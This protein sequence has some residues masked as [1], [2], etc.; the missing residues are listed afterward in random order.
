MITDLFFKGGYAGLQCKPVG[1][2]IPNKIH[3]NLKKM[4]I[5]RIIL[6]LIL[7][8]GLSGLQK[9]TAQTATLGDVIAN[10]GDNI[11]VPI[12]FN[13]M[14][15]LGS[16]TLFILFDENVLTFNG[17][18]NVVPE[19]AGTFYNYIPN[20]SSV[21]LSWIAPGSSGVDF[22][23][24]KY[25]DLQFT[26]LGGSTDLTFGP[27]EIVD[28]N[29]IV[30]AV[31]YVNG[32]VSGSSVEFNIDVL[33]EGAYQANSGG[34]MR[35]DL[36]GAGIL[37]ST[38]PYNPDLPYFGNSNPAWYYTGTETVATLPIGTVDWIL[39]ELR[40]A[41]TLAEATA[42]SIVAQKPCFLLSDGSVVDEM[43]NNPVFY[44]SFTEGAFI[45]IWHRN[46][47]GI[48]SSGPVPGFGG[49]YVYNFIT[50]AGKV[51]GGTA[52]Y[53]ELENGFW[54]MAA[55]D[56]NADKSIN[57]IDKSNAWTLDAGNQ[58]YSG[59]DVN[60]DTQ[61]DNPDKNE[62]LLKNN[63]KFSGIPD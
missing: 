16:L 15:N 18:T 59:A 63:G 58:G 33:L 44:T 28:W 34:V 62:L 38:Q 43:G 55:G 13:G 1:K 49:S 51:A 40:D 41:A 30:L 31:T 22:P 47:I 46:H 27:G 8:I 35:T 29:D 6:P 7:I 39:V 56:I 4:Q 37:P 52:G 36:L 50:G 57:Q 3:F 17:I 14:T 11:L 10:P 21:G 54:G 45:V 32:S 48:M 20:P 9:S 26:F 61:I 5:R 2:L 53:V 23:D 24:G 60:L 19:G 25:L 42:S 12:D